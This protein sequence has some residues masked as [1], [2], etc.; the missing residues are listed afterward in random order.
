MKFVIY[1]SVDEDRLAKIR[2]TVEHWTVVNADSEDSASQAI[3]D[4]DCFFGKITP[5]LLSRS[6]R[7]KWIQSPTA[8]LEHYIFPELTTHPAVLTNMRGLFS[9]VIADHVMGYILCFARQLATYIR[10]QSQAKW[11]PVGGEAGRSDFKSGP[12]QVSPIDLKH[13]QL[14]TQTVG[15]VGLGEIGQEL[16]RR[17]AAFGMNV[18]GVDPREDLRGI[19]DLPELSEVWKPKDLNQLLEV[20][21]YVVVAAPHTPETVG[22][23]ACDQFQAM[24]SDAILINIGRGALVRLDDLVT[25][26]R[27][28]EIGGAALDVY[29]IEPLPESHPLWA[30]EN[31]ILTPHIAGYAPCIAERHLGVVLENVRAFDQGAP[32]Q[33]RVNKTLWY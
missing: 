24:K 13:C 11:A 28:G 7:L 30:M 20:A 32:L 23:F 9:D 19:I 18:V 26:L 16:T 33:N 17:A 3:Q 14:Q 21:D 29:E 12:G 31:V 25:S 22:M 15:I 5:R 8:S 2:S 4:A 1:T 6:S 10:Q 27:Q